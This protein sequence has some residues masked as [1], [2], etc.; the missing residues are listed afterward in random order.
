MYH[1]YP[2]T[3][4]P[5]IALAVWNTLPTDGQT[6]QWL[7]RHHVCMPYTSRNKTDTPRWTEGWNY[8]GTDVEELGEPFSRWLKEERIVDRKHK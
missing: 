2:V 6:E 4:F 3:C 8:K 5:T 7:L 1:P